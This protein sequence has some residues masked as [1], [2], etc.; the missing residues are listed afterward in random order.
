VLNTVRQEVFEAVGEADYMKE[1][2]VKH[3]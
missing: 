2:G 1:W 3:E